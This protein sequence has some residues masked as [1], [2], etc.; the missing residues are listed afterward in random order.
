MPTRR[1]KDVFLPPP[2][3]VNIR[4][5]VMSRKLEGIQNHHRNELE[6]RKDRRKYMNQSRKNVDGYQRDLENYSALVAAGWDVN[7]IYKNKEH[8]PSPLRL[9]EKSVIEEHPR[10]SPLKLGKPIKGTRFGG[11]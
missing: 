3:H 7:Q 5:N 8:R 1:N 10:V 4:R 6:N 2:A 11:F 9:Y